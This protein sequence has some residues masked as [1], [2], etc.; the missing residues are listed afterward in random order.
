MICSDEFRSGK[1]ALDC[2][3]GGKCPAFWRMQ[4]CGGTGAAGDGKCLV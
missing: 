1:T 4:L 3:N 2:D